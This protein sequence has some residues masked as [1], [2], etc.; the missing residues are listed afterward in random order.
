MLEIVIVQ[1]LWKH[2]I[3]KELTGLSQGRG[4]SGHLPLLV[5]VTAQNLLKHDIYKE[6]TGLSQGRGESDH[7]WMLGIIPVL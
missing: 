7:L 4:E 2:N 6:L 5:I 3:N 1:D